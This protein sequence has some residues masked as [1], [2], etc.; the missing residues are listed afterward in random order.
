[1]AAHS[2]DTV[3]GKR[4][5][6]RS[7]KEIESGGWIEVQK[8]TFTRWCNI[9]LGRK[10]FK[11]EDIYVDFEDGFLL[12][13]LL[14][15]ISNGGEL[16]GD[17]G[18]FKFPHQKKKYKRP[19]MKI[20]KMEDL[21]RGIRFMKG[22]GL[23]VSV[24]PNNF[25]RDTANYNTG[26]ILGMVWMLILRYEVDLEIDGVS[27]KEGLLRW[28]QRCTKGYD[29]VNVKNFGGSWNTGKAFAALI[30]HHRPDLMSMS[31]Y[32]DMSSVDTL[33]DVFQIANRDLGIPL[34]IDAED[35]A[36][37]SRPDDR[38]II[39]YVA[40]L[41]K[42]FATY[43]KTGA[44]VKSVN[45]AL[46]LTG[47]L[48]KWIL[49]YDGKA[50]EL[51]QW[52]AQMSEAFQDSNHGR[53]LEEIRSKLSRFI[54]YR[55]GEK[56]ERRE[57][58]TE[59]GGHLQTLNASCRNNQRPIYEPANGES[60][61]E[62]EADWSAMQEHEA[63]Y[64][65]S[66]RD[67][68]V[69]FQRLEATRS[70]FVN[71]ADQAE[72]FLLSTQ[73]QVTT[74]KNTVESKD[75]D[76]GGLTVASV[77]AQIHDIQSIASQIVSQRAEIIA[78]G[79]HVE[80]LSE[81]GHGH[82]DIC[83]ARHSE[84][85]EK[86]EALEITN[87]ETQK[88]LDAELV[89]QRH[90]EGLLKD[91]TL[92][93]TRLNAY[94]KTVSTIVEAGTFKPGCGVAQVQARLDTLHADHADQKDISRGRLQR[95]EGDATELVEAGHPEADQRM[96]A[97][98][99]FTSQIALV[100]ASAQDF[101][102]RLIE[103]LEREQ[104][105]LAT[106]KAFISA[107]NKLDIWLAAAD[108]V[109]TDNDY[110]PGNDS[111]SIES[112]LDL[113]AER[114]QNHLAD[115]ELLLSRVKK[116]ASQLCDGGHPDTEK[117]NASLD[118]LSE[119]FADVKKR[120]RVYADALEAARSREAALTSAH[121]TFQE[122]RARVLEWSDSAHK[123]L[124]L[125]EQGGPAGL[126][127]G[128]GL[129][130]TEQ[131]GDAYN[132]EYESQEPII[133][134]LVNDMRTLS[135][136]LTQGKHAHAEASA[137]QLASRIADM[138]SLSDEATA[139]GEALSRV[140]E[141]ENNLVT[142][143][144][145]FKAGAAKVD[146]WLSG[147][148]GL[149][150]MGRDGDDPE[151][152]PYGP[153]HNREDIELLID[154]L[155]E[156]YTNK[157]DQNMALLDDLSAKSAVLG[158]GGH[159]YAST[160]AS[161]TEELRTQ[162]AEVSNL[163]KRYESAL[164]SA[165]QRESKLLTS[166]KAFNSHERR[167]STWADNCT[168]MVTSH[169]FGLGINLREVQA[170]LDAY[171]A[172]YD[173]RKTANLEIL[174]SAMQED[175]YTLMEGQHAAAKDCE[176][177][178]RALGTRMAALDT[179]AQAYLKE[180][181][182]ALAREQD[183]EANLKSFR[184]GL[185]DIDSWLEACQNMFTGDGSDDVFD[186]G[187]ADIYLLEARRD[188]FTTGYESRLPAIHNSL[189]DL[190]V[191]CKLLS[192][193]KHSKAEDSEAALLA[194]TQRMQDLAT[195]AKDYEER[196]EAARAREIKLEDM[197]KEFKENGNTVKE[198]QDT[199]S[200]LIAK[201]AWSEHGCGISAIEDLVDEFADDYKNQEE[202][203]DA[204]INTMSQNIEALRSGH[205]RDVPECEELLQAVR[206]T[207]QSQA[208]PA[209]QYAANL[210]AA[211]K[212][213][214]MLQRKLKD[215]NALQ[216]HVS[217][218][219]DASKTTVEDDD[220]GKGVDLEA[221]D[222][223]S[224]AFDSDYKV[225]KAAMEEHLST[226]GTLTENLVKGKHAD[227][228]ETK[229]R[230]TNL[231]QRFADLESSAESFKFA[232]DLARTREE[233]LVKALKMFNTQHGR[234][235]AWCGTCSDIFAN[236]SNYAPGMGTNLQSV[237]G[238]IDMYNFKYDAS[239]ASHQSKLKQLK[240]LSDRLSDGQ[241]VSAQEVSERLGSLTAKISALA[242]AA[243]T[244]KDN[245]EAALQRE[246]DLDQ[247]RKD[248]GVY[249][250]QMKTWIKAMQNEI[251][252]N[253]SGKKRRG[254]VLISS[255]DAVE[256]AGASKS[257]GIAFGAGFDAV[258]NKLDVFK[259]EY[260]S[261]LDH[262]DG[263]STNLANLAEALT[264]GLHEDGAECQ[265]LQEKTMRDF[266]ALKLNA[267]GYGASLDASLEREAALN[268]T[269][270][271][272]HTK[273]ASVE[274]WLDAI[275]QILGQDSLIGRR[276]SI[277]A[278]KPKLGLNALEANTVLLDAEYGQNI[279]RMQNSELETLRE[280]CSK[281]ADGL[282]AEAPQSTER[283]DAIT[284]RM[285]EL[286]DQASA[287]AQHLEDAIAAERDFFARQKD[288]AIQV[289]DFKF[290]CEQTLSTVSD[291]TDGLVFSVATAEEEIEKHN[292]TTAARLKDVEYRFIALQ[293]AEADLENAKSGTTDPGTGVES[294]QPLIVSCTT[295]A[296]TRRATLDK[297]LA[298]EKHK[299]ELRVEF[300]RIANEIRGYVDEKTYELGQHEGD[301]ESQLAHLETLQTDYSE[302]SQNM[303]QAADASEAQDSAGVVVNPHTPETIETLR[304]AWDG[305]KVVYVKSS[306]AI[307]AQILAEQTA[308]L[309]PDQIA[310]ANEVFD[311]FDSDK[312]GN[313]NLQEFHDCCTSLGL[314]LD[315]D[316][317]AAKHAA[318]DTNSSGRVDRAEFL[319]F[320]ADELT[321]SDSREDI[322][323]AFTQLA[324]GNKKYITPDQLSKHF[325]DAELQDYLLNTMP[326]AEDGSG[327]LDFE[328][329]SKIMYETSAHH[330][331][332][333]VVSEG[334][335]S[336]SVSN[337][338]GG[339]I[340]GMSRL[341]RAGH[342]RNL[343]QRAAGTLHKQS[344]FLDD[345]E[346]TLA[347]PS[348]DKREKKRRASW[349]R[350]ETDDGESYFYDDPSLGGSGKTQWDQPENEELAG[351]YVRVEDTAV[352]TAVKVNEEWTRSYEDDG[353]IT[354][355]S[356]TGKSQ[357]EPP[358]GFEEALA[359]QASDVN[360]API[361]E[362]EDAPKMATALYAYEATGDNQTSIQEMEV[363]IILE[364]DAGGWTGVQSAAGAGYVPSTYLELS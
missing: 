134:E 321:H 225:Q 289:N 11:I 241:H 190:G 174:D 156:Q 4:S 318:M 50:K 206:H 304:A 325:Q 70:S 364:D 261:Q 29:G 307:S 334:G 98:H 335:S 359:T 22:A 282:H 253:K 323:E 266:V 114:Y 221:I 291:S 9:Y 123:L 165:L 152:V 57:V 23:R 33:N 95:L 333:P 82:A 265:E 324:E 278:S 259:S 20:K 269:L 317:A 14:E 124:T 13:N 31:K 327:S 232:L 59:L 290:V 76:S 30:H 19:T 72:A 108:E 162:S 40:F 218:W 329:F 56:P 128:C 39:P 302:R 3:F 150:I 238:A 169:D 262:F 154:S 120:A 211:Y 270:Q 196:L 280:Y 222:I 18:R 147:T 125:N 212:R 121:K 194:A 274:A 209:V 142:A 116:Y 198:W 168:Q 197:L 298:T 161:Q 52:I 252:S 159:V 308:G 44:Y 275:D 32:D 99:T 228:E 118:A 339:E 226:M 215:F 227:A 78:L 85:L 193:G 177:R 186:S 10:Q 358:P 237:E 21:G 341:E 102:D 16:G 104:A 100:D 284:L 276:S 183:L 164:Q 55:R 203:M 145:L 135:D 148:R 181:E 281:L 272:F 119:K 65:Q 315:K 214:A 47:K 75:D 310:E 313:L 295:A 342:R 79:P 286:P 326:K 138:A 257:K 74:H 107:S 208:D 344:S 24:E 312:N 103:D 182:E 268:K 235:S 173:G 122:K 340:N 348:A 191:L 45:R 8:K 143:Q 41:F 61:P 256:G 146:A 338:E 71:G 240:K 60:M 129:A 27:G 80:E 110:G 151:A 58:L 210:D 192:N 42:L 288:L 88:L 279:D 36:D 316:E 223:R 175:V 303:A 354:Y 300:A 106:N 244:Y 231:K 356:N 337:A 271:Y 178:L 153:G 293:K 68:Y 64:Q 311:E 188:G 349:V 1:M 62:L 67:T 217:L 267:T 328:A 48:S 84:L 6:V 28:C 331:N 140:L 205:H 320:Y 185:Q 26:L 306:E 38:V 77:E 322:V 299:E 189:N 131:K 230:L 247:K 111:S 330:E 314:V 351:E 347:V 263:I 360:R 283:L 361:S 35:I 101:N 91:A 220:F 86:L 353:S 112:K 69:L 127:R 49:Q 242:D 292:E 264:A 73:E 113:L 195:S 89:R 133:Q 239:A 301:L 97:F 255:M 363:V 137:E 171:N 336:A 180:L 15:I 309:N 249:A 201:T 236:E 51:K 234:T 204:L 251:G 332:I 346:T 158:D 254:S 362:S 248:F 136:Q 199:A 170:K 92:Q 141:R 246:Q 94:V 260:A 287:Y 96:S 245:L 202:N 179:E 216:S 207:R 37:V 12:N 273:A 305:L 7:K 81:G 277:D 343:T 184:A 157:V 163:V 319:S 139:Y 172:R 160:A 130:S 350:A 90:I 243:I 213:E 34:L 87:A 53:D 166:L 43:Q 219:I 167:I 176:E 357:K 17:Q 63:A 54:E 66:L 2:E 187:K 200:H 224:D 46:N 155:N 352:H 149:I 132:A 126:D 297:L 93:E 105:L 117:T 296:T 258:E 25:V 355:T 229:T 294:L 83:G 285:T 144:K 345:K 250:N 109:I 233:G 115:K 5:N